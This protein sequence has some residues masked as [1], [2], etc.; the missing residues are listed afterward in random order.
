[1]DPNAT[2][3]SLVKLSNSLDWSSQKSLIEMENDLVGDFH[4]NNIPYQDLSSYMHFLSLT[5]IPFIIEDDPSYKAKKRLQ[6]MWEV[7]CHTCCKCSSRIMC[8]RLF[9]PTG[10]LHPQ[11]IV[12]GDAPAHRGGYGDEYILGETIGRIWV[13]KVTSHILRKA[14]IILNLHHKAW[15]TNALKR[16]VYE[17]LPSNDA[18]RTACRKH[19]D[20][21]IALLR[22]HFALMLGNHVQDKVDLS[23]PKVKVFH[24]SFIVRSN[25]NAEWYAK[26]IKN[27]LNA[28]GI[29]SD[30]QM[31]WNF[32]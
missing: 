15:Y 2:L 25:Y 5:S 19:L 32:R 23:I 12:I 13:G 18:E 10:N 14:L 22:P 17:N 8:E 26:H 3:R 1:M 27:R 29:V 7:D 28:A 31:K 4:Y 21:E 9:F 16:S 20:L 6:K 11:V 30:D 24:P